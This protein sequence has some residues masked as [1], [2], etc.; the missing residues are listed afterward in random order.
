MAYNPVGFEIQVVNIFP[1]FNAEGFTYKLPPKLQHLPN[2][3]IAK[4]PATSIYTIPSTLYHSLEA[5][6]GCIDFEQVKC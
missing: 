4:L 5:P 2:D 6:V 1:L 3:K